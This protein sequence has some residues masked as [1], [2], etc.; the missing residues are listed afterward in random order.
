M[1]KLAYRLKSIYL[2]YMAKP[3]L[4]IPP[5]K[6]IVQL[7]DPILRYKAEPVPLSE[8]GTPE[9][10]QIIGLMAKAL[11]IFNIAGLSAPQIGVGKRIMAFQYPR[12]KDSTYD[13]KSYKAM[14]ME[15]VPLQFW[16]NPE[17]K[18][19]DW[20]KVSHPEGCASLKGLCADVPRYKKV[21]LKGYDERG[22]E[23]TLEASGW[24]ARIIQHEMDHLDGDFFVDKMVPKTLKNSGWQL[25]NLKQ[26]RIKLDFGPFNM[27]T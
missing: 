19:L 1:S 12:S 15:E 18:I 3:K 6:H 16:I 21:A 23:K 4:P 14:E 13:E 9:F 11:E 8:I 20:D 5:Y 17:L 26:G 24:T 27:D 2:A 22:Q 7:G 10:C 25:I